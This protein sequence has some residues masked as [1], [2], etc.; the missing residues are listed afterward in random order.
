[1]K[2]VVLSHTPQATVFNHRFLHYARARGF[3]AV[4]CNVQKAHEKG[5]AS[6][7]T[8][9]VGFV[10]DRS[11]RSLAVM[12]FHLYRTGASPPMRS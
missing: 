11:R 5:Y 12:P 4:A 2:T 8:S 1:M 10:S 3:G 9:F 7:C 6:H